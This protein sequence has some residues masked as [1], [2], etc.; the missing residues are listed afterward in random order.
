[1]KKI[2]NPIP[3]ERRWE[4]SSGQGSELPFAYETAI[5]RTAPEKMAEFEEEIK[6]IW[7]EIGRKRGLE[8][9]SLCSDPENSIEIA[10]SLNAFSNSVFGRDFGYEIRPGRGDSAFAVAMSCP[11]MNKNMEYLNE[12]SAAGRICMNYMASIVEGINPDYTATYEKQ[13]CTGDG[14]CVIKIEKK[15]AGL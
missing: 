5:R 8:A 4:I 15:A 13:M 14:K 2:D 7:A 10:E 1:M 3:A 11:L 12:T 6:K 9:R